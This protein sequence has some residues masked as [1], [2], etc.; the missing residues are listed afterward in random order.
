MEDIIYHNKGLTGLAN[1]G[2]TCFVNSCI[3]VLIHLEDLNILLDDKSIRNKLNKTS[4]SLI[5]VEYDN[6]RRLMWSK[7][8]II[9]PSLDFPD[10]HIE[11]QFYFQQSR[12]LPVL[13]LY[14]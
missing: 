14:R 6:I 2:N 5:L 8:C 10:K 13:L 1:L 12:I 7:N 9:S 11:S 4:D 3:Q